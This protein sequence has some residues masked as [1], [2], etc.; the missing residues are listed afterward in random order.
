MKLTNSLLTKFNLYCV[1][2]LILVMSIGFYLI[3]RQ[4]QIQF[5]KEVKLRSELVMQFGKACR[6][7]TKKQLRPRVDL[8]TD[9]M[10]L[11]A[12]SSTFVASNIFNYLNEV[13]PN[14]RYS[15]P[16]LNPLNLDNKA[17]DKESEII[18][19]FSIDKGKENI[20]GYV[21]RDGNEQYF[22]AS[23]IRVEENC[24]KCHGDPVNAPREIKAKYGTTHGYGWQVDQVV[25]TLTIYV[26]TYDLRVEQ[27]AIMKILIFSFILLFVVIQLFLMFLVSR[28]T[29]PMISTA[30]KLNEIAG[31]N[32]LVPLAVNTTDETG[33]LIGAF[34]AMIDKIRVRDEQ[35]NNHRIHLEARVA[36]QTIELTTV[37]MELK[38]ALKLAEDCAVARSEF[39][40]NIS[41]E[42]RTPLNGIMGF[43]DLLN[44]SKLNHE[45]QLFNNTV[46]NSSK[47]LLRL[48]NDILD[49]SKID[50]GKL[51]F[52]EITFEIRPLVQEVLDVISVKINS[53]KVTL[54]AKIQPQIPKWLNGDPT[55]IKQ[56]LFNLMSNA[57][58]FTAE[59]EINLTIVQA[60]VDAKYTWLHFSLKDT[61]IGI[62][63]HKVLDILGLF[64]QGDNSTTRTF[65]G[66]GLGLSITTRLIEHMGGLLAIES[67]EGEGSD[68]YF[69][70][71]MAHAKE[72]LLASSRNT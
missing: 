23:P 37:N 72:Y 41:H 30:K 52:E 39:L 3:N 36:S 65:G 69:V 10:V 49:L 8:L 67:T 13:F 55:R 26:P 6:T 32:I 14:Y 27:K 33:Y 59:G 56:I 7:Y 70:I 43:S 25:A 12:K 29:K 40:A 46:T 24:L 68:F 11:E 51:E 44:E 60:K 20:S 35:L 38:G 45:Q 18:S 64:S 42:L 66:T 34:N 1:P 61:G 53:A 63:A 5:E 28:I 2:G 50:A 62:P 15:Q 48:I 9:D 54:C 47:T 4:Q 58:K 71:K 31:D 19:Q 21:A 16:T 22:T 57:A 17:N